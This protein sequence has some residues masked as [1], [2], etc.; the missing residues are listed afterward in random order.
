[1]ACRTIVVPRGGLIAAAAKY[2]KKRRIRR[3]GF[4]KTHLSYQQYAYLD[5]QL[6]HGVELK[7]LEDFVRRQRMIKT[8]EEIELI[9]ESVKTNSQAFDRT[10]KKI[11]PGVRENEI[12]AELDYQMRAWERKVAAFETIVASGQ[13]TL[14]RTRGRRRV[15]VR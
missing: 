8:E 6:P 15:I 5:R 13:R 11:K 2:L 4:E 3:I 12:A 14:C 1:V 7:P 10:L 9:R